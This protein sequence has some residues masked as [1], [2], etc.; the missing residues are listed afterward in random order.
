M[1]LQRRG[2]GHHRPCGGGGG[3]GGILRLLSGVMEGISFLSEGSI[4]RDV[5]GTSLITMGRSGGNVIFRLSTSGGSPTS[6]LRHWN[7][8]E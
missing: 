2:L 4:L 1:S 3:G 6:Y 5:G 7:S 8:V